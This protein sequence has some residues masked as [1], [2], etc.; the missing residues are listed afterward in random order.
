MAPHQHG[1]GTTRQVVEPHAGGSVRPAAIAQ[2]R[3]VAGR[4]AVRAS[5]LLFA[6]FMARSSRATLFLHFYAADLARSPDG[7]WWVVADRTD[8][9]LGAGY[10][11]ENRIV[12]SRMLPNIIRRC[13]VERLAPFFIAL[14]ETL[15]EFAPK[16]SP[17]P[18]IV[19]LSQGPQ[20]PAL[21]RGCLPGAVLGLHAGR[22]GR[23]GG[24]R[25]PCAA[26][27]LGRVAARGCRSSAA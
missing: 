1:A 27:D 18:R 12:V 25:R 22:I 19:L 6:S 20:E 3:A 10:A 5:R 21:L 13:R 4:I 14:R 16:Q 17:N 11:L 8:A 23:S 9:P 24:A 7:R 2:R 26:E 15:R